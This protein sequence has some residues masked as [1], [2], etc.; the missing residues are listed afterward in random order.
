MHDM[1]LMWTLYIIILTFY[2][3]VYALSI[4]S[5]EIPRLRDTVGLL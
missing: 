4:S 5:L 1:V 2:T 3:S